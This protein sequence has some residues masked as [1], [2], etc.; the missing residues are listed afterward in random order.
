MSETP[1]YS[2]QHAVEWWLTQALR[3]ASGLLT[4]DLDQAC[5]VWL[6][7]CVRLLLDGLLRELVR[8]NA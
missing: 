5:M 3:N 8:E 2:Y 6:D 1:H 4:T 7:M